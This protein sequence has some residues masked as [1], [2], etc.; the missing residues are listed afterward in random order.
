MRQKSNP[1]YSF[2]VAVTRALS[3]RSGIPLDMRDVFATDG[4]YPTASVCDLLDCTGC[5]PP[6]AWDE[7]TDSLRPEWEEKIPGD[8]CRYPN[9]S[10]AAGSLS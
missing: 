4:T 5:F 9:E 8:W 2:V 1:S 6:E 7:R 10:P 3:Y